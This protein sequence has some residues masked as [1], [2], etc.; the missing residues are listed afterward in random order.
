MSL[1]GFPC[2]LSCYAPVPSSFCG[3]LEVANCD[4]KFEK[5]D[6]ISNRRCEKVDSK[7][8]FRRGQRVILDLI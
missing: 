3:N 7:I 2:H 4:L 6:E 8:L 5:Y 1:S